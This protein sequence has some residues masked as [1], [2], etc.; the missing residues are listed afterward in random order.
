MAIVATC[1]LVLGLL[2]ER[3]EYREMFE[4][5][6]PKGSCRNKASY[7]GIVT[8]NQT[9]RAPVL[10]ATNAHPSYL[11]EE[12]GSSAKKKTAIKAPSKPVTKAPAK[13]EAVTS[14]KK[15]R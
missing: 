12:G 15:G 9:R 7:D 1:P 8:A 14:G 4:Q 3:A 6:L 10:D 11:N 5:L 13:K 2:Y